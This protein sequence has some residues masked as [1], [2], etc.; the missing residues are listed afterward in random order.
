[1]SVAKEAA[2]LNNVSAG[3]S[4]TVSALATSGTTSISK[5]CFIGSAKSNL[6]ALDAVTSGCN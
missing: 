4:I 6:I 2:P 1:M 5:V 3:F